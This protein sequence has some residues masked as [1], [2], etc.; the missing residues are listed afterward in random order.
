MDWNSAVGEQRYP[1]PRKDYERWYEENAADLTR[2]PGPKLVQVPGPAEWILPLLAPGTFEVRMTVPEGFEAYARIFFPFIGEDIVVDGKV[3]NQES[4]RWSEVAR[5]NGRTVHAEMEAEAIRHRDSTDRLYYTL[6]D[7]LTAEQL[8]VILPIL[9]RHTSTP[10]DS[11]IWPSVARRRSAS[12]ARFGRR[13]GCD[14]SGC[15]GRPGR[16]LHDHPA[17]ATPMLGN[18][19]RSRGTHLPGIR[20]CE[21]PRCRWRAST[22]G[23]KHT[24]LPGNLHL[25]QCPRRALEAIDE[26]SRRG[27]GLGVASYPGRLRC[28]H[29][30]RGEHPG[31]K[32]TRHLHGRP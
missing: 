22:K 18:D 24:V 17:G 31:G 29:I 19:G 7:D 26:N 6:H 32:R 27:L 30:G 21:Q 1:P 3:V 4:V 14:H 28:A 23:V 16:R 5:L 20:R 8:A 25:G 15:P 2:L 9:V 13:S 12:A 11:E 10:G